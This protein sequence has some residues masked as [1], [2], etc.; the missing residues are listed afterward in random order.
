M[1]KTKT[2]HTEPEFESVVTYVEFLMDD[3]ITTF[4]GAALQKL[5]A[6]LR[7][8]VY[9]LREELESYGL[10]L[11]NRAH[12]PQIRGFTSPNNNRWAGNPNAGGS[13]WEQ[14]AGF[15]GRKG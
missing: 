9:K 3:N 15:A 11:A 2:P 5:N 6:N 1:R 4:T 13:G 10:T 7:I 14:I 12:E 8:P